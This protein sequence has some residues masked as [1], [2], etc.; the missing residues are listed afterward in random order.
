MGAADG[1]RQSVDSRG[2][3]ESGG[4]C[5]VGAHPRRVR[6]VFSADLAEFGFQED[7][8]PCAHSAAAFVAATLAS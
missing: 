1:D 3:D 5:G 6:A 8:A 7:P 2:G 4:L